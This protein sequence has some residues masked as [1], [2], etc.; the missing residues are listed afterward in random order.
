MWPAGNTDSAGPA[1]FG[2]GLPAAAASRAA[3][4]SQSWVLCV[5]LTPFGS[6]VVPADRPATPLAD[7]DEVLQVRQLAGSLHPFDVVVPAPDVGDDQ[8][9]GPRLTQDEAD[10]A[11]TVDRHDRHDRHAQLQGGHV[12][13]AG[14]VPGG[15]H[16][17]E[18]VAPRQAQAVERA[19]QPLG[20]GVGL[21]HGLVGGP[22]RGVEAD[23]RV[24]VCGRPV[25]QS[26]AVGVV[27]VEAGGA[28]AN[29]ALGPVLG[30][31]FEVQH[32]RQAMST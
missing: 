31:G 13:E 3:C 4:R 27:G 5:C 11:R 19:G 26:V 17:R 6:E 32:L 16:H 9:L 15:E 30:D 22:H 18:A 23:A 24:P 1:S 14:L 20:V 12:G 2:A 10:L 29:R 21:S 25:A 8:G 28:P 7:D